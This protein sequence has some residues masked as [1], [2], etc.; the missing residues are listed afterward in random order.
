MRKLEQTFQMEGR[1][2]AL[3]IDNWPGHLSASDLTN[4]KLIFLPRNTTSVLQPMDL[5][6][7]RSLKLNYWGRVIHQ[8]W[9][10]LDK[11]KTVA[12]N[13]YSPGDEN[14]SIFMESCVSTNHCQ[15]F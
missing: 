5:G 4:V 14:T 9:R 8:L 12:K 7:I 11:T 1:K 2:I 10:A 6:V 15:L 13:I 3:L